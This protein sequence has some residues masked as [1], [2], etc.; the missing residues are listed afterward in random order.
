MS[1]AAIAAPS[2]F[3]Q[4]ILFGSVPDFSATLGN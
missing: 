4:M 3:T 2:M 1:C